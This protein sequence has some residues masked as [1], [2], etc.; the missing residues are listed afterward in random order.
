MGKYNE[1]CFEIV[2]FSTDLKSVEKNTDKMSD[3]RAKNRPN[4]NMIERG[5]QMSAR[6]NQ[7]MSTEKEQQNTTGRKQQNAAGKEQQKIARKSDRRT[8]YTKDVIRK[9]YLELLH[10]ISWEKISVTE[11]CKLADINRT[12]FYL[13]Y[14]TSVAV[15][16]EILNELFEQLT[17]KFSEISSFEER[18]RI[19]AE[20]FHEII[21]DRATAF[22][23]KCG[24]SYEP[25][26]ERLCQ[27]VVEKDLETLRYSSPLSEEELRKI[28]FML[29]YGY[30]SL[31]RYWSDH[32]PS[33]EKIDTNGQLY[34]KYILNPAYE[35]IFP[36]GEDQ[37]I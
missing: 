17:E 8:R 12:T 25:F 36:G 32:S 5:K 34:E 23:I 31:E 15:L 26:I 11:I 3:N 21:A 2:Q 4:V 24:M 28:L 29:Y 35:K 16:E 9:A 14:D 37:K 20:I 13:H 7:Q 27:L 1:Q 18:G 10:Q 22:L 30:F 6:K 33:Y 19:S